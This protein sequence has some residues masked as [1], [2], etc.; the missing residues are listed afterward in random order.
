MQVGP[1][2][3]ARSRVPVVLAQRPSCLPRAAYRCC[4]LRLGD[5]AAVACV[6]P[7]RAAS[8]TS[9]RL[10]CAGR[11]W[12]SAELAAELAAHTARSRI[13]SP[14]PRS[15]ARGICALPTPEEQ[16][17]P[18]QAPRL[19]DPADSPQLERREQRAGHQNEPQREHDDSRARA[20]A[21]SEQG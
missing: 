18:P 6:F 21:G 16:A 2:Q 12:K 9:P 7:A 15:G 3:A 19:H 17:D 13:V 8:R 5:V 1:A 11:G 4:A 20:D 10:H 14:T